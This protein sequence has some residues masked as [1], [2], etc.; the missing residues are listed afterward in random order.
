M[1]RRLGGLGILALGAALAAG[2]WAAPAKPEAPL[3]AAASNRRART[4]SLEQHFKQAEGSLVKGQRAAAAAELREAAKMLRELAARLPE[5][6][7]PGLRASAGELEQVARELAGAKARG[8]TRAQLR[9][10]FARAHYALA[11]SHQR[12]ASGFWAKKELAEA[13]GNLQAAAHHLMRAAAWEGH[14]LEP[15]R[16]AAAR[17]ANLIGQRLG[18]GTAVAA[19]RVGRTIKRLGEEIEA[20]GRKRAQ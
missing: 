11:A 13:G 12:T 15:A 18:K 1:Q 7:Q 2:A 20:Y 6:H 5:D 8:V 4:D 10:A 3:K 14:K 19:S 9:E 16:A 17:E